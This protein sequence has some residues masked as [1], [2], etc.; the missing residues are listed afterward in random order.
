MARNASATLPLIVLL[1]TSCAG[2]HI[3]TVDEVIPSAPT[4]EQL[5]RPYEEQDEQTRSARARMVGYF[6]NPT[7][8]THENEEVR[9]YDDLIVG[10]CVVINF[11]YTVCDGI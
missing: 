4:Q 11:M 6:P 1:A 9:F 10:K 3:E 5:D 2:P 7:L 8:T